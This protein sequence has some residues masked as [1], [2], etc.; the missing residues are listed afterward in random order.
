MTKEEL[1]QALKDLRPGETYCIHPNCGLATADIVDAI[2][3]V[4][5][6]WKARRT[7]HGVWVTKGRQAGEGS[8]GHRNQV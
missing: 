4:P 2:D 6:Q 3:A 7:S 1:I 5:G 8:N